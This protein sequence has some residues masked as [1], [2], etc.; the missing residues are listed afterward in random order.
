VP[1][2][3][4]VFLSLAL[5][6]AEASGAADLFIGVN[7]IDYSGYPDCRPEFIEAFERMANLA[8][9]A[10]TEDGAHTTIHAPLVHLSKMQTIMWGQAL[11]VDYSMTWSCYDP[12]DK[13]A[14]GMRGQPTV[15]YIPCQSC[16]SCLLRQRAFQEAGITDPARA[17]VGTEPG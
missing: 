13:F 16:D 11:G 7:A 15:H 1:A 8:T 5:A 12:Q 3:N 6:Y 2:R 14:L 4:T 17:L 10:T 9:K